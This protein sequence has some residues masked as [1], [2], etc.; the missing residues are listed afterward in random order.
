MR[1]VTC[2]LVFGAREL[3]GHQ[4]RQ[5]R[6]HAYRCS[7]GK[8][9]GSSQDLGRHSRDAGHPIS[10]AYRLPEEEEP[11][12]IVPYAD[13]GIE[14]RAQ[15]RAGRDEN[16]TGGGDVSDQGSD[17]PRVEVRTVVRIHPCGFHPPCECQYVDLDWIMALPEERYPRCFE[18]LKPLRGLG[19]TR[20]EIFWMKIVSKLN[21]REDPGMREL[22]APFQTGCY[23]ARA[24][25]RASRG[26]SSTE[27][28]AAVSGLT[29]EGTAC[30]SPFAHAAAAQPSQVRLPRRGRP[31][32]ERC[33]RQ[34]PGERIRC[35][36]CQ[37]KV[38]PG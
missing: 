26:R 6:D 5:H 15:S 38:G 1:C 24:R 3:R 29:P 22:P 30:P 23:T 13:T 25:S 31:L 19:Y 12:E 7:C 10:V 4:V 18:C 14:A 32:C 34:R 35:L 37:R 36:R 16:S 8:Q 33:A 21:W 27:G 11:F 28:E 20:A 9:F 2:G 17:A